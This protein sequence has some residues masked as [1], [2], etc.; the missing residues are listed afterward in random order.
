MITVWETD[1]GCT[2]VK[3]VECT[4]V[5]GKCIFTLRGD[6]TESR[7]AKESAW[8]TYHDTRAEAVEYCRGV[9]ERRVVSAE[10]SLVD[11][12][13]NLAKFN[14]TYPVGGEC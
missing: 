8:N 1:R 14:R 7:S 2:T 4:R 9:L 5:T 6:K 11:L 13:K 10:S 3:A 12:Q